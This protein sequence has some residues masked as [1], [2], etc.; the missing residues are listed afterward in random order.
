M[1]LTLLTMCRP[2]TISGDSSRSSIITDG[3]ECGPLVSESCTVIVAL[4]CYERLRPE[5][6]CCH[7][8]AAFMIKTYYTTAN[9]ARPLLAAM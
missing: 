7:D 9:I 3:F 2:A 6:L 4:F 1:L 5:N 8:R